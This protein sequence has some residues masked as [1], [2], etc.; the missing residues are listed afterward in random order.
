MFYLVN[1]NLFLSSFSNKII[2]VMKKLRLF[3]LLPILILAVGS[4]V[5]YKECGYPRKPKSSAKTDYLPKP[6]TVVVAYATGGSYYLTRAERSYS[7][8]PK[9]TDSSSKKWDWIIDTVYMVE[10]PVTPLDTLRDSLKHPRFDPASHLPI[11]RKSFNTP[12]H[13]PLPPNFWPLLPR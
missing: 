9:I 1:V 7:K 2:S 10:V 3:A 13:S 6:D 5:I 11:L 12:V 8:I 4:F